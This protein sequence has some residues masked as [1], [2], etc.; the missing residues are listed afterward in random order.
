[1]F[2]KIGINADLQATDWGSVVQRRGPARSRWI[3]ADVIFHTWATGAFILNPV[4]TAP[5]RG[6][7]QG[8]WF[9]WYDNPK[10]EEMTQQWLDAKDDGRTQKDRRGNSAGELLA[11]PDD[12]AGSV[13]DTHG[14]SQEPVRASWSISGPCSGT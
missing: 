5:F 3:R 14:V 4:V 6:A 13:P 12:N 9:G 10:I 7:G 1:M 8:G 2:K 11:G